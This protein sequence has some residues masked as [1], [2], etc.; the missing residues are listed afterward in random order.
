M[1]WK[2][3]SVGLS[4]HDHWQQLF[5]VISPSPPLQNKLSKLIYMHDKRSGTHL[6]LGESLSLRPVSKSRFA[7]LVM[8]CRRL[9]MLTSTQ[10]RLKTLC[11]LHCMSCSE[12]QTESTTKT[13]CS[14]QVWMCKTWFYFSL[15][16]TKKLIPAITLLTLHVAL[17][18]ILCLISNRLNLNKQPSCL[19]VCSAS[20]DPV[21]LPFCP[22][23][24]KT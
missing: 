21:V 9:L 6:P 15:H 23:G 16:A 8:S 4:D 3:W 7:A 10:Q 2:R 12:H 11:W 20:W 14:V 1:S 17:V 19:N 5:S 13:K 22:S 24:T 18:C